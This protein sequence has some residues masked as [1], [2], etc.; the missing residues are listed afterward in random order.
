MSETMLENAMRILDATQKVALRKALGRSASRKRA[1]EVVG[2]LTG[3]AGFFVSDAD[4]QAF[5][6]AI[7]TTA[8]EVLK[9]TTQEY[10]DFQTPLSLARI[11][12]QKLF[13]L[14][15][16]PKVLIEPTCGRGNFIVAALETFPS[17]HKIIGLEIHKGYV[18]ECK[19]RLLSALLSRP[20][21]KR[22]IQIQEGNIFA[23]TLTPNLLQVGDGEVMVLGNPPWVTNTTLSALN[24][25][26]L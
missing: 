15:Y 23:E 25:T 14:G 20:E 9:D 18:T 21:L 1:N 12:C 13:E 17:I 10:G 22:E 26:N 4:W 8:P 19:A 16:R 11:V 7:A 6:E 5:R 3:I 24:S 2:S